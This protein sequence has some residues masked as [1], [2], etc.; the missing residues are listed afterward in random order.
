PGA[1]RAKGSRRR[2][3]R[4]PQPAQ[5]RG[6]RGRRRGRRRAGGRPRRVEAGAPEGE[7]GRLVDG[8]GQPR[9]RG[10]LRR[11]AQRAHPC[12]ARRSVLVAG[13][14]SGIGPALCRQLA[15]RHACRVFLGARDGLRGQAVLAAMLAEE[16]A[17][18][19]R[20]QVVRLDPRSTASVLAAAR[21]VRRALG[22][23]AALGAL[24]SNAEPPQTRGLTAQVLVSRSLY[25]CEAFIPLLDPVEGRVVTV[26]T[27]VRPAFSRSCDSDR[28]QILTSSETTW[29]EAELASD[30]LTANSSYGISKACLKVYSEILARAHPKIRVSMA[31]HE[32]FEN[33]FASNAGTEPD[34]SVIRLV[35]SRAVERARPI[36]SAA[37]AGE[38]ELARPT[39]A[40]RLPGPRPPC[41][42]AAARAPRPP[43]LSAACRRGRSV[44]V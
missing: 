26:G 40:A 5:G 36:A 11:R 33:T 1:H 18:A 27:S 9:Q 41:S 29:E 30:P 24:V 34:M 35:P 20:V 17:C 28:K 10:A 15:S 42:D 19:G 14:D 32:A 16:P 43:G 13:G 25:L 37:L 12:L 23:G 31:P 2:S 4:A 6:A 44:A 21:A 39:R 38:A 3:G 22:A 7:P 8:R